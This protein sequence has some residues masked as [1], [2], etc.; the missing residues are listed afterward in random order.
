MITSY[1]KDYDDCEP[2]AGLWTIVVFERCYRRLV[3]GSLPTSVT[4]TGQLS[5]HRIWTL[6]SYAMNSNLI[7]ISDETTK[8]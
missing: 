6:G 2:A 8:S 7:S 5:P 1:R 3:L 4:A